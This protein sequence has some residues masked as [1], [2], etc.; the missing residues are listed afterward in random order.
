VDGFDAAN[1][2]IVR[3]GAG[4]VL[5]DVTFRSTYVPARNVTQVGVPKDQ[6]LT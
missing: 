2:I 6:P 1:H 5:R 4:N 3:D